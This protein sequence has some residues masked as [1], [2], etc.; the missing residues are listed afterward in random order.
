MLRAIDIVRKRGPQTKV[1]LV[2]VGGYAHMA[3]L[4]S[5]SALL[6]NTSTWEYGLRD[7]DF[8]CVPTESVESYDEYV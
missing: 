1:E 5:K 2:V 7:I 8:V 6:R 3:H 4:Q